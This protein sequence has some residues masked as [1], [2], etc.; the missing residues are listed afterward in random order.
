MPEER[1]WFAI[2][3]EVKQGLKWGKKQQRQQ[4]PESSCSWTNAGWSPPS[5]MEMAGEFTVVNWKDLRA[6]TQDTLWSTTVL[7]VKMLHQEVCKL[8]R[9]RFV[10]VLQ[11]VWCHVDTCASC[12]TYDIQYINYIYMIY[13]KWKLYVI[14]D[15][16]EIMYDTWPMVWYIYIYA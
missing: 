5:R 13:D 15:K 1:L 12:F 14:H 10:K 16:W 11:Y 2:I 9:W 3:H 7:T 8:Q 6:G 4:Q